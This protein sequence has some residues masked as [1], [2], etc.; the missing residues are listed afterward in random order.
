M[1][2]LSKKNIREIV[3]VSQLT[4]RAKE[5]HECLAKR[6]HFSFHYKWKYLDL[7]EKLVETMFR[8]FVGVNVGENASG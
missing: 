1:K 5:T 6:G 4:T 7:K 2:C 3:K 8:G